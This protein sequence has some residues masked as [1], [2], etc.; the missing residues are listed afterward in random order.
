MLTELHVTLSFPG[1]DD[2]GYNF[3]V[4]G[5]GNVYEGRGWD[6]QGAHV[7]GQNRA[8]YGGAFIGDFTNELPTA[9]AQTGT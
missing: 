8:S 9:E 7:K 3:L 4:G 2:I 6:N 5:D 1:W